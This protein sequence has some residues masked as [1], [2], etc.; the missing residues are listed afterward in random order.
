M[1][2]HPKRLILWDIDGTLVSGGA[3]AG[4]VF[5]DAVVETLGREIEE[6]GVSM[7]GKTDPGIAREILA[8]AGVRDQDAERMLADVLRALERRLAE[9]T[10]RLRAE[11]RLHPGVPEVLQRLHGDESVLQSVLTGNLA[12]NARLKL[13]VFGLDDFLDLDVGAFGSDHHDREMLVPIALR[14]VRERHAWSL[15]PADVWVVGDTP[16]DL[17]CA[18]AG[19]ARCLLVGTGRFAVQ[20]LEGLGAE[21][22]LGDLTDTPRVL[23]I[24]LG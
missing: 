11:G 4:E 23:E 22:V 19:G 9:Q 10:A 3:V 7:S 1:R 18:K 6:H 8:T 17:A 5:A 20:E 21:A 12:A 14:R 13:E 16:R 2:S 15:D 24:L